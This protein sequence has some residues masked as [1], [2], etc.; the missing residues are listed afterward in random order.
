MEMSYMKAWKMAK[1]LNERFRKPLV[2]L[3]RGGKEQGGAAL[4]ETGHEVLALY[5]E[6][7][8]VAEKASKPVLRRMRKLLASDETNSPA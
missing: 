8:K 7:V 1:G 3:Q 2:S 6:A 4:T 5:R